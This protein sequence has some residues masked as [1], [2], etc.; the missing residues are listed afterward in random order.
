M[1]DQDANKA[2]NPS[3]MKRTDSGRPVYSGGGVEPDR[4]VTGPIEGFNP[5]PFGRILYSRQVFAAYAQKFTAEGDARIAQTP[6][7]RQMAKK[8]FEVDDR[9]VGDFKEF[10]KN[11]RYKI[12]EAAWTKDVEFIRGMI[13]FE[14]DSAL[15]G[16]SEARRHLLT[17]AELYRGTPGRWAEARVTGVHDHKVGAVIVTKLDGSARGGVLVAIAERF[18]LPVAAIG[19]GE[20]VDDLADFDPQAFARGLLGV[21]EQP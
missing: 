9:M 15:F 17:H 13:R 20:S 21:N 10:V 6:T 7:G 16:V 5:T 12:D 19:V 1:K 8:D 11:E 2:H 14:I 3:D 18:G 4:H